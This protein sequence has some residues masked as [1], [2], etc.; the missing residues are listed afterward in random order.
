MMHGAT[1]MIA[2]K[3]SPLF[4]LTTFVHWGCGDYQCLEAK[5]GT[6][7]PDDANRVVKACR[8][9]ARDLGLSNW[10][11]VF[12]PINEDLNH[13]YSAHIDFRFKRID[14]YDSLEEHCLSN[15]QKPVPQRKNTQLMLVL[16][17]LTEVLGRLRG[18]QVKFSPGGCSSTGW[19]FDPHSV[20]NS[21]D[22]GIHTLWHLQHVLEY[23]QIQMD[24]TSVSDSLRF[25]SDMVGKRMRLAQ[26]I[27][28]DS[29]VFHTF[30]PAVY[31]TFSR[32]QD[33][34]AHLSLRRDDKHRHYLRRQT[35]QIRSR[36][37]DAVQ[38]LS[39]PTLPPESRKPLAPSTPFPKPFDPDAYQEPLSLDCMDVDVDEEPEFQPGN[40][41]LEEDSLVDIERL[42]DSAFEAALDKAAD[43]LGKME[44]N[45]SKDF[46]FLPD[47]VAHLDS[48]NDGKNHE[49]S[50]ASSAREPTPTPID[51]VREDAYDGSDCIWEWHPTAGRV[52]RTEPGIHE[53]WKSLFVEN[54]SET[55]ESYR[56]FNS[57][58]EWE[59]TQWAVKQRISQKAFDRL[60]KIPEV[61]ER[62]GLSFQ[63]ARAMLKKADQIP[64]RYG[65][66]QTKRLSFR[67]RPDEYFYV[68]HLN[69]IE[70]IRAVWGDPSLAKHLVYKPAQLFR[71]STMMESDRRFSEMWT[72]RYWNAAQK[73]VPEGGTIAT[74]I[75]ASD[76]TQLTQFSGNKSAYPV[77]LTLGNIPKEIRRQ[78]GSR[79]CVLIAYLSVDKPAKDDLSK[80]ALKLR[81]YQLFH[82]SMA[83]VLRPLK[84]AGNPTKS[85]VEMVGGDGAVRAV[86]PLLAS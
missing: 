50:S 45:D 30:H 58:L 51:L 40:L 10:D 54:G 13:W 29:L 22:C 65:L 68:H 76:K 24:K 70:A 17:W 36:F 79:A 41:I 69:P 33:Q 4:C 16:M 55:A 9:V 73:M 34:R 72:G 19:A 86:Y 62:L 6:L 46:N 39:N 83:E 75:I 63:S 48:P 61:K 23:R 66:W 18:D 42:D 3:S 31:T 80:T 77:Y 21:Y 27:L 49:Q 44:Q 8:K 78:P 47:P 52:L 2:G 25:T 71:K 15:R 59:V 56:P 26:E 43:A 37:V 28:R 60:L 53:G 14:I 82:R 32:P 38:L 67:D 57:R 84:V 81:N 64:P 7:T 12:I 74:V 85:G 5:T 20:P 35:D 11:S 1:L